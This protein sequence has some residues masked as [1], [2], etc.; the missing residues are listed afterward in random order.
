MPLR[1]LDVLSGDLVS[2]EKERHRRVL[3]AIGDLRLLLV[4]GLDFI[5]EAFEPV[6]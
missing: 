5:L 3:E 4:E 2:K 1:S 6:P